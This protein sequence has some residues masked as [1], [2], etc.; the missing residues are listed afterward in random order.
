MPAPHVVTGAMLQCTFGAAPSVF[1]ATPSPVMSSNMHVG[2]IFDNKPMMNIKPFGVCNA[3]SNPSNWK[4]PVFTPGPC[5]PVTAIGPWAPPSPTILVNGIPAFN[6]LACLMC[7]W[8]GVI[9][10]TNPGQ[11]I[12]TIP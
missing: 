6:A 8:G 12:E 1:T 11:T 3:P 10:P 2:T 4:G 7:T 9:K 5:V